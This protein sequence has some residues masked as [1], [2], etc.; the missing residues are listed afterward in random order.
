MVVWGAAGIGDGE[1]FEG[2]QDCLGVWGVGRIGVHQY[3]EYIGGYW[4]GVQRG[5]ML[6]LQCRGCL[7]ITWWVLGGFM[8]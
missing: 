1:V 6:G 8:G 2:L 7:W 3:G 4:V 5:M